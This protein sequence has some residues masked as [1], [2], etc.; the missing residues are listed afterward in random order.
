MKKSMNHNLTNFDFNGNLTFSI[1][2]FLLK[3][4]KVFFEVKRKKKLSFEKT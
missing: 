3:I 2:F 4:Q 1:Y